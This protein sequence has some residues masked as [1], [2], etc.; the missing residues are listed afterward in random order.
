MELHQNN[1]R[2]IKVILVFIL[3]IYFLYNIP[4]ISRLSFS[5]ESLKNIFQSQDGLQT[6]LLRSLT[7]AFIQAVLLT[8]LGLIFSLALFKIP[9]YSQSGKLLS[10]LLVP[11]L[12][13]NVA[14]A[15]IFKII[16]FDA[17]ALFQNENIK[18]LT[19]SFIQIW[20]FGSLF[21]YLFWLNQQTIPQSVWNYANAAHFNTYEKIK[22]VILPKQ[23]NLSLLLFILAFVFSYYEDAKIQFIFRASRGTNTELVNQWLNRKFQSDSLINADFGFANIS[24]SASIVIIFAVIGL[25]LTLILKNKLFYSFIRS[26]RTVNLKYLFLH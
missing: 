20:Q 22:D 16:L 1:N 8:S 18:F 13:G 21:I 3:L 5:L 11:I 19:L 2:L 23:R 24:Q 26:E 14:I 17:N 9:I 10:L 12:L 7:F 4:F 25:I 6:P 15:F